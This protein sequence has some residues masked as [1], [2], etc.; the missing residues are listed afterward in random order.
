MAV[1]VRT[2]EIEH[3]I[4]PGGL[5]AL[6]ITTPD[7]QLRAVEGPTARVQIEFS[8]RASSE[9]EADEAF[10]RMRFHVREDD[11]ELEVTEPKHGETG[12][13]SIVRILGIG[14]ARVDA[15]I[16]AEVPAGARIVY[17]GVSADVTATGFRGVQEFRS[18]SGDLVLNDISGELRVRGVSSDISLRGTA[19]IRLAINTVSGD[20]S[21]FAPR[22]DE[23]RIGTVSGD[24]DL[25]GS[26]DPD[27]QH[28]VE[29]VS[30]DLSLG[31]V[32]DLSLEVR[33]LST[34]VRLNVPH[35][36]EG[37]R[38]RRRYI[39]GS[40]GPSLLFSSMSGDVAVGS[41]RRTVTPAPPA[42]PAPPTPPTPPASPA[43]DDE[44]L[45]ILKALERGEIDVGEAGRRLAG[46]GRRA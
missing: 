5:F 14:N 3:D 1:F 22:F 35:R 31:L 34:D 11:G 45:E 13:G 33:G 41:A 27:H 4:G 28:R 16:T 15:S 36:T 44:Q 43:A 30:G 24:L 37:S 38:G 7:A 19:P 9:S 17:T 23:L 39:V 26:L 2:Q 20:A 18:V 25:E 10:E 8:V 46:G 12:L 29:T 42:P 6:R 21:A 32:G 40:G